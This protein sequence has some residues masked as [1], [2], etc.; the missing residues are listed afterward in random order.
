MIGLTVVSIRD[1][2]HGV[3]LI[4]G[5]VMLVVIGAAIFYVF[6][7]EVPD[8]YRCFEI[9]GLATRYLAFIQS[10]DNSRNAFPSMHCAIATYI[11]LV[12]SSLPGIGTWLGIGQVVTDRNQLCRG[13]TAR[14][15]RHP[16]RYRPGRGRVLPQLR[17]DVGNVNLMS[18]AFGMGPPSAA[19]L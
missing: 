7:T 11:G 4:F 18:C 2:A 5:G 9:T 8:S 10:M 14:A 3:H 19:S 6:P 12:V 17:P 1:L 16:C 15:G 13:Q